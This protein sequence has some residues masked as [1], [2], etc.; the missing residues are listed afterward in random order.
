M[1][2]KK[3]RSGRKKQ[4]P[5]PQAKT[6]NSAIG[7]R[8]Q[9]GK[10]ALMVEAG[11]IEAKNKPPEEE[12]S[13]RERIGKR[14]MEQ[15]Y[16]TPESPEKEEHTQEKPEEEQI[17]EETKTEEV[18]EEVEETVSEEEHTEEAIPEGRY[19]EA[20]DKMHQA[21]TEAANQ[22]KYIDE[23][24]PYVDWEKYQHSI[25]GKPIEEQME[26][27]APMTGPPPMDL[28]LQDY[29]KWANEMKKWT[30]QGITPIVSNQVTE[31]AQGR[32]VLAKYNEDF[33]DLPNRERLLGTLYSIGKEYADKDPAF[34]QKSYMERYE[35]LLP[36]FRKT[37]AGVTRT[38]PGKKKVIVESPSKS[39]EREIAEEEQPLTMA[40]VEKKNRAYVRWRASENKRL[41]G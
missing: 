16:N 7:S 27:K 18:S 32:E 37:I 24:G 40:D 30:E 14:Y 25:K 38:A 36:E 3:G 4:D 41:R 29:P 23:I 31:E 2:G 11:E 15:T 35:I 5:Q 34:L 17:V 20:V 13:E 26:T 12:I 19:K 1:A 33:K 10:E 9:G 28:M 21:T 8:R 6:I 22:R 39:K